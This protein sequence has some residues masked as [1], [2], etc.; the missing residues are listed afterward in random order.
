MN[1]N[2]ILLIAILIA[3]IPALCA[4]HYTI[5]NNFLFLILGVLTYILLMYC[6][7]ILFNKNNVSETFGL[8]KITEIVLVAVAAM[9]IY[10][11][12]LSIQKILGIILGGAG[13]YLLGKK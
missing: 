1:H 5:N 12:K 3:G 6:Y 13:I 4:K 9:L 8:I 2:I 10:K 11:E 7:V